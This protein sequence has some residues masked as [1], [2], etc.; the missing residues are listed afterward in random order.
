MDT[1]TFIYINVHP[2]IRPSVCFIRPVFIP[3]NPSVFLLPC[4]CLSAQTFSLMAA[5]CSISCYRRSPAVWVR[6]RTMRIAQKIEPLL[7][8]ALDHRRKFEPMSLAGS[9]LF[10]RLSR[11]DAA[12]GDGGPADDERWIAKQTNAPILKFNSWK[13]SHRRPRSVASA[14][15]NVKRQRGC[16]V[17]YYVFGI[18][19]FGRRGRVV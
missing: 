19:M 8:S 6:C 5:V 14:S 3:V 13:D 9:T 12:A 11:A 18:S 10:A 7:L 2:S 1:C 17:L 16:S 4:I 15:N